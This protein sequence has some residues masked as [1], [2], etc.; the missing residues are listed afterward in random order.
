M[1]LSKMVKFLKKLFTV[2]LLLFIIITARAQDTTR[3]KIGLTLSGGGAKGLAHIGI[4]KAIDSAGLKIDYITG[5]SMG[6]IVGALYAIG[7]SGKQIESIARNI[8]WSLLLSN[9]T[10]LQAL[11]M[12][13]KDEY[14]RYVLELPFT[15]GKNRLPQGAV[16][17]QE[18]WLKLSELLF[19]VNNIKDFNKLPIPF[20]AIAADISTAETVVQGSGELVTALR[21]SIAIPGAFT[22]VNNQGRLLVDGGLVRNFPV[23][24]AKAMGADIVIGSSVLTGM[25]SKEK[26]RTPM[27]ALMQVALFKEFDDNKKQVAQCDYYIPHALSRF[28]PASF[29]KAAELIDSG[30]NMGNR[31]Y[32]VIKRLADSIYNLYEKPR[33][34]FVVRTSPVFI[35]SY[36]V[37]GLQRITLT[38]FLHSINFSTYKSYSAGDLSAMIRKGFGTRNYNFIHYSL[39]PQAD[40]KTRIIFEV[41]ER[42]PSYSKIGL[43]YNSFSGI[44]LIFNLTSRNYFT[45]NSRSLMTISAGDNFRFRTEH[46]QYFG[47]EKKIALIPNIQLET[48]EINTYNNHRKEGLYRQNYFKGDIKL[49]SANHTFFNLGTGTRYEWLQYKPSLASMFQVKGKNSFLDSYLFFNINT[50]NKTHYPD[51]GLKISAEAGHVYLQRPDLVYMEGNGKPGNADSSVFEPDNYT[52]ITF[53]AEGF[54]P[55][56]RRLNLSALIQTGLNFSSKPDVLNSFFIGGLNRTYRNQIVF[57]GLQDIS[58]YSPSVMAVQ[59]SLRWKLHGGISLIARNNILFCNFLDNESLGPRNRWLSGHSLTL[60]YNSVIGPIELSGMYS[61]Q[62][63]RFES[64]ISVG[65]SF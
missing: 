53:N 61:E 26:I 14:G 16:E 20:R 43:H 28:N 5:T 65:F 57:A 44:G 58:V 4:L 48:F 62:S 36:E 33:D 46:L 51:R 18:L 39:Q 52:Q 25:L 34:S 42:V 37:K 15:Q 41:G 54:R 21:A 12:E 59:A 10:G 47:R 64:Y 1:N 19:S 32:P 7:Y 13:E 17:G 30:I 50:L 29:D 6:S 38:S 24:D 11:A 3:P 31:Y 9:Q 56:S 27:Q 8:D 63:K 22:P 40:G 35:S 55:L 49:Q 2:Q 23:S 45:P 60:S